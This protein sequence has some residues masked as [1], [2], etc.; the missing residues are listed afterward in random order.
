MAGTS[1]T[2]TRHEIASADHFADEPRRSGRASKGVN[3]KER[4]IAEPP[5]KKKAKGK[6]AKAQAAEEEDEEEEE[7]I[8]RCVCG[9]YEEEDDV[10]RAMICCDNCSAW[11]HNDCMGLAEDYAPE[12]YFCEQCRP[13]DHK[14]MV[15]ALKKGEKPWEEVG[16]LREIRLA[17]E[18]GSK[19]KGG[20]KSK[21]SMDGE[22]RPATPA[23]GSKRKAED[24]P[25]VSDTKVSNTLTSFSPV[26]DKSQSSKRARGTPA[27]E[28][29][30][31]T[32]SS[33]KASQTPSRQTGVAVARDPKELLQ[34]RQG[35]A[36]NLIKMFI[37]QTKT[38]VKAGALSLSRDTPDAHGTHIGLLVEHA[39]YQSLS[40]GS[41][42]PNQAYKNQFRAIISNVKK[43][44]TLAANILREDTT[45]Q[46]LA[47]MDPKKMASE[48]QQAK[49]TAMRQEMERQH[50]I[51]EHQESGPRIRRTHKGDEY[52]DEEQAAPQSA[53][54]SRPAV[55][56][57][58]EIKS[59]EIKS[60]THTSRRQPSVT[61]PRRQSSANFDINKVFSNVHSNQD[62]G[63]QQR[64]GE[65][66][67]QPSTHEPAGPGARADADIDALL[68]DEDADSEPYSPKDYSDDGTVWRGIINGG[69][70]G[71]FATSARYAA[72]AKP[73]DKTLRTT[74]A[75][76]L[77][78][79]IGING[80]IQPTK[81]DEYLCGLEFSSSSDMLVIWMIEPTH[82]PDLSGFNK[83]FAYFKSKERFGVGAQNHQPAL[84]DIYFVPMDRGQEMP[85]FV[86]KLEGDFPDFATE[87]GLLV[88]LVVRNTELPHGGGV[89]IGSPSAMMQSPNVGGP[90]PSMQTPIT[91]Q[92]ANTPPYQPPNGNA[93]PSS[94]QQFRSPPQQPYAAL[95]HPPSQ[96]QHPSQSPHIPPPA[97]I[98]AARILGP[99]L[100]STP[101]VVDLIQSAP[102]AGDLEMNVVKECLAENPAAAQN[103]G[104][105]TAMLQESWARQQGAAGF[106]GGV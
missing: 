66:P 48:E 87:R 26:T 62:G 49:E 39:L 81:A 28:T 92:F 72:G 80:R 43:N 82:E 78:P 8:I 42:D 44:A 86:K 46:A 99:Q 19:K 68:K 41:G 95:P 65:L 96:S 11:Q 27:M 75:D 105:L 104:I 38:A 90:G 57:E 89:P 55:K 70:T 3:T 22:E 69:N 53:P 12:K 6:G 29:N 1:S 84:K 31:K 2:Q 9:L 103:L 77:P 32:A 58:Q 83:F 34:P 10:P 24:S 102:N 100:A 45:P 47:T 20:K 63:D 16:R 79:E 4:D 13:Q 60:P 61:I 97:A 23:T 67:P 35:P 94:D 98:A 54:S 59:P 71:R 30:G 52:V 15:A 73:E 64:F 93:F 101:A 7:E 56:A 18:K 91:P 40:G 36:S 74:W 88:P 37:E 25:A 51:V 106:G 33:R 21:K 17:G 76:L 14:Q 50:S 5:A 85:T